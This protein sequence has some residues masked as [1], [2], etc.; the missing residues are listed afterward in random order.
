VLSAEAAMMVKEHFIDTYGPV[1]HTIGWGASG[2]SI[3]Q[4]D[5]A[6]A[7]PGLLDVSFPARRSQRQRHHLDI[8]SDCVLMD[9]YSPPIPAT[10]S[11]SR[12]PS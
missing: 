12:L 1:A 10:R 8:V 3:Q 9:N 2:G 4:Y 5:I 6:D 7:Y 11:P